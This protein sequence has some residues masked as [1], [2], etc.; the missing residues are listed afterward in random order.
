MGWSDLL[1]FLATLG[2]AILAILF[3]LLVAK[4]WG[5]YTNLPM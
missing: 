3:A 1:E 2:L 4:Y 5:M